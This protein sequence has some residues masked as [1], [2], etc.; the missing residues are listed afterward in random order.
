MHKEYTMAK[1]GNTNEI[2]ENEQARPEMSDVAREF[3]E[4]GRKM[5]DALMMAWNSK[6]RHQVE[7]EV[8][9][10]V[11]RLAKEVDEGIKKAKKTE[12]SQKVASQARKV[13]E[14]VA[15]AK[16]SEDVRQ[17]LVKA[18]R[19]LSDALDNLAGTVAPSEGKPAKK[20]ETAPKAKKAK[21][22]VIVEDVPPAPKKTAAT[23]TKKKNA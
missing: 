6:E 15:S 14:E 12:A 16:V 20:D 22:E 18:L 1:N 2:P 7:A 11:Q 17:G 10:G 23:T 9:E 4:V 19:S 3:E 5:R 21:V 13:K 8:R